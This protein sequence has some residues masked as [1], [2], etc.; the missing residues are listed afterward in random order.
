MLT[1][2]KPI[3]AHIIQVLLLGILTP[4]V[5]FAA[6]EAK[7]TVQGKQLRVTY[8]EGPIT[9]TRGKKRTV[10][11]LAEGS[12]IRLNVN[13]DGIVFAVKKAR[14][15]LIPLD[16]V[17]EVSYDASTHRVS[18]AVLGGVRDMMA[19]SGNCY[20]PEGCGAMIVGG[21][22]AAAVTAP[23]KYTNHFVNII[24]QEQ[25]E[26]QH[27]IFRVGK[28]DYG[29]LL[30]E[31]GNATGRP[32]R[33]LAQEKK[34]VHEALSKTNHCQEPELAQDNLVLAPR[35]IGAMPGELNAVAEC[36]F[37]IVRFESSPSVGP[38]ARMRKE[39]TPPANY[40]YRLLHTVRM[41]TMQKEM[42]QAGAQG[43]RLRQDSLMPYMGGT[44]A[45]I[46]ERAPGTAQPHSQYLCYQTSRYSNI[47]KKIERGREQGYEP[48]ATAVVGASRMLI[49]EKP[50]D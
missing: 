47:E 19:S 50:V 43:F 13:N 15:L 24:W 30:A 21:L 18:R 32:W 4:Q 45:V 10:R 14:V 48:A 23:F 28:R 16:D 27:L 46:M 9:V 25:G 36:G 40:E 1:S 20:P 39:A 41:S 37:R 5:P 7:E 49:L 3:R 26:E 11:P 44:L 42:N 31:L 35:N 8:V 33:N 38:A 12:K 22:M 17:T 6:V 29:S 2:M 34:D